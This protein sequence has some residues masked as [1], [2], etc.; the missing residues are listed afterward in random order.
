MDITT[1]RMMC[2]SR[3]THLSEGHKVLCVEIIH[4]KNAPA[5]VLAP[6]PLAEPRL[7]GLAQVPRDLGVGRRVVNPFLGAACRGQ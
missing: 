6:W 1:H 5:L 4:G 7:Q 2:C 3:A